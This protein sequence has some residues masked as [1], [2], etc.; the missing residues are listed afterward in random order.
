MSVV[1]AVEDEG[2][3][4]KEPAGVR[5]REA[6]EPRD[7]GVEGRVELVS[8]RDRPEKPRGGD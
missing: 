8:E 1:E 6:R 5:A 3:A 7:P 4:E 2:G